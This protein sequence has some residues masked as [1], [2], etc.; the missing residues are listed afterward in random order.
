MDKCPKCGYKEKESFYCQC[1]YLSVFD[2]VHVD[3]GLEYCR[4]CQRPIEDKRVNFI[5]SRGV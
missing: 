3:S 2:L 5:L 1:K 4:K